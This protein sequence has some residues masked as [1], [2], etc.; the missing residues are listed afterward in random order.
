MEHLRLTPQQAEK[1][2]ERQEELR[3]TI[4]QLSRG[5]GGAAAHGGATVTKIP[6]FAAIAER[7]EALRSELDMLEEDLRTAEIVRPD[8]TEEGKVSVHT[9]VTVIDE[10]SEETTT[11]VYDDTAQKGDEV[12][13]SSRSPIGSKLL[14]KKANTVV[15]VSTPGGV[16]RLRISQII[17]V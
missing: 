10:D 3:R 2:Y 15:R 17:S 11:Y 1:K 13:L 5:L 12:Y 6:E 9:K 7:L 8:A 16:K 4:S 14:G